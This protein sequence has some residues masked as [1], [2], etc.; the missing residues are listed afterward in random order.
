MSSITI[1]DPRPDKFQISI[2]SHVTGGSGLAQKATIDGFDA[3]FYLD[4][5]ATFMSLPLPEVHGADDILVEKINYTT[6]ISN[7]DAFNGF[8]AVLMESEEFDLGIYGETT[9]HLGS[10]KANVKYREW[11]T[12]KGVYSCYYSSVLL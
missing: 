12:L 2:V 11:V 7:K 9:I 4:G 3:A 10:V 6:V 8:A 1:L 5:Q